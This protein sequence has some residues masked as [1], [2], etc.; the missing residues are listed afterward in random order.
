[1]R[2]SQLFEILLSDKPSKE[3]KKHEEEIFDLVPHLRQTKGFK[4]HSKWHP[5]DVYKHTLQVIDNTPCDIELRLAA[6]FHDLGK[7]ETRV[8]DEEGRGHFPRHE[9]YSF[10]AFRTFAERNYLEHELT[11]KVSILIQNHDINFSKLTEEQLKKEVSLF[12]VDELE[13]LF[14]LKQAD[15][16]GQNKKYHYLI[17][18]LELEKADLLSLKERNKVYKKD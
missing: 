4:Q 8:I 6:L 12:S 10:L 17:T 7:V 1:M 16:L 5:H 11:Y 18:E 9:K 13:K 14:A 2:A 3:I 15:L